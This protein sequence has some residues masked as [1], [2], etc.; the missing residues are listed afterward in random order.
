VGIRDFAAGHDP[1]IEDDHMDPNIESMMELLEQDINDSIPGSDMEVAERGEEAPGVSI[2]ELRSIVK[3]QCREAVN[4]AEEELARKRMQRLEAYEGLGL[5]TDDKLD[6]T[7][8]KVVSRDVHDTV[9]KILPSIMRI[10][11]G[12]SSPVE[13]NPVGL[14]DIPYAL[15]ATEYVNDIVLK[16]DN[17][18]YN[19]MYSASHDSL[20]KGL[21]VF[22]WWWEAATRVEG[23]YY[24]GLDSTAFQM[25]AA[26]PDVEIDEYE[27]YLDPAI[28]PVISCHAKRTV[29]YDGKVKVEAVP[30]EERLISKDA[31]SIEDATFYGHRR[32]MTVSELVALGFRYDQVV[33]FGGSEN[34]ETNEEA[35]ERYDNQV[36]NESTSPGDPS[37]REL[38]VVEGYLKVDLD[39][40][41]IAEMYRIYV[42]GQSYTIL[43]WDDGDL[44]IDL[45]DEVPF[46]EICPDPV[47]HKATGY[48]TSDKVMDV[49]NVKTNLL[50]GTLDSLSR[51]IFPREEIVE[52][53][54]NID[55]AMNPEIGALVRVRAPGMIREIVTPFMGKECLPVLAYMDEVKADRTGISDATMGLNPQQ[56][57]SSTEGAVTNTISAAQTQI[58]MISRHFSNGIRKLFSGILG[59][60]KQNQ[61]Q[62]RTVRLRNEWHAV[63]PSAWNVTMDASPSVALGRGT[64]QDRIQ[65]LTIIAQKQEAAIQQMGPQNGLCTLAEYRNT[66]AEIV[67][68]SG[69]FHADQFFLPVQLGQQVQQI[70]TQNQELQGQNQQLEQQAGFMQAELM[71][72]SESATN[73]DDASAEKSRADAFAKT[74]EAVH[75]AGTMV[76]EGATIV[77]ELSLHKVITD[78]GQGQQQ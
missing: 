1:A 41:G 12:S 30:P 5:D 45:C 6:E 55:D 69:Y 54:V 4:Y 67:K 9:H 13:Y 31:R 29:M 61:D 74:V 16:V 19:V 39:G 46:A 20:V 27:E 66:L 68:C 52:G 25:L 34:L 49:Q 23:S 50:R 10:F 2:E 63:D 15:Q 56:L 33:R 58:E 36:F 32:L 57:Q 17:D 53:Q 78:P 35:V 76:V 77:D 75:E 7:R 62:V 59:T 42:G 18:F 43:E 26:E 28:G 70:T 73:K 71:K 72:R 65:Y 24:S 8:S 11:C 38:E 22:K 48:A 14:E 44:A 60:I 51:A 64:E 21:G 3:F 37:L 47:P 40:D